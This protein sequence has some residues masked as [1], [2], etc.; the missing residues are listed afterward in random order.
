[1]SE[2]LFQALI[3]PPFVL[4][5]YIV[6]FGWEAAVIFSAI[7]ALVV[8]GVLALNHG[9]RAPRWIFVPLLLAHVQVI[10][11]S[12]FGP[13]AWWVVVAVMVASIA[14]LVWKCRDVP[15]AGLLF[16]CFCLVYCGAPALVIYLN[17]L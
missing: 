3:T 6:A 2:A 14:W 9:T 7:I 17:Q 8:A 13:A 10:V 5:Q 16:A 4:G 12:Q 11:H 1:M 15:V